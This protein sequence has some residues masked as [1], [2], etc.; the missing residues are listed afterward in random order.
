[1]FN[2]N[3][4]NDEE[5]G[6]AD[7]YKSEILNPK[8]EV[9]DTSFKKLITILILITIILGLSILGYIYI[10]NSQDKSNS[11]I[12]EKKDE[13]VEPPKSQM[14]NNIDELIIEDLGSGK[15]DV[16]DEN[17]DKN[18]TEGK[19]K[20]LEQLADLSDEVDTEKKGN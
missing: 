12:E 9:D 14:L 8:D 4:N 10:S 17:I 5:M 15:S 2:A 19:D 7:A 6:F 13:V 20:Y 16:V 1:M 3:D 11:S 18:S